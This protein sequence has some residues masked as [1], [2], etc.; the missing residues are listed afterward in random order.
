MSELMHYL[1]AVPTVL[2]ALTVHEFAHGYVSYLLGDPTAKR[3]GRLS[4]NPLRHIDPVGMIFMILCGFVWAKPVPINQNYYKNTKRGTVLV[5]LAGPCANILLCI[6]GLLFVRLF[7]FIAVGTG[8]MFFYYACQL[9][10]VFA[11]MNLTLGIF[12]L[13]PIPPLDGGKVLFSLLPDRYYG[14]YLKYEQYGFLAVVLLL[15]VSRMPIIPFSFT[16]WVDEIFNF[17]FRIF[18]A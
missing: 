16:G 6:I 12:N 11:S 14:L 17:L 15:V 4:L 1:Y 9:F 5:S 18:G 3:R 13:I 7:N 8:V 2:A 10:F